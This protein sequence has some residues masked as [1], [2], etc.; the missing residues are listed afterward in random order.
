[1]QTILDLYFI[2]EILLSLLLGIFVG[3]ERLHAGKLV[4]P[5]TY[6]FVSIAAT[7][8]THLSA[9][10]NSDDR[11][12]AAILT[13]IGFIGAGTILHKHN[14]VEGLTSAAGIWLMSAVG[15]AIGLGWIWQAVFVSIL[16][17]LLFAWN[18]KG[19]RRRPWQV[20]RK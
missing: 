3:W 16:M 15:I 13:G 8:L 19:N 7:F 4:G 2:G 11:V 6:A 9:E 20:W 14:S 17:V 5:R 10:F 18:D 12:A 1:M